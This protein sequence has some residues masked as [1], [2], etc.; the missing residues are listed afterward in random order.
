MQYF[1]GGIQPGSNG[2][3]SRSVLNLID[4]AVFEVVIKKPFDSPDTR[5]RKMEEGREDELY[6]EHFSYAKELPWASVD[7]S[8]RTDEYLSVGTAFAISENQL[9]TAAHVLNLDSKTLWED[10]YIR[11]KSGQVYEL[12]E[13]LKYANNRDFTLFT[14][15]GMGK[16]KHFD[17]ETE[18]E[19]N[20]HV[21]AVGNALGEGV[22]IRDGL[23]TSTTKE[24]E[25]GAWD[26]LR[27]S[28]AAS[29]GNSGGPLLNER[30]RVLGIVL[31][32]S[33]NENLNYALPIG[34]ALDAEANTAV[35]HRFVNYGLAMTYKKYGPVKYTEEIAL[36]LGYKELR[37]NLSRLN[38]EHNR[39]MIDEL[40]RENSDTMFPRGEGSYGLLHKASSYSFPQI[41]AENEEDG[42]WSVYQ[43]NE[44]ESARLGDNGYISF[45]AMADFTIL[46][47]RKP[48]DVSLESLMADSEF[49]IET[50]L[51]AYPLNRYF[52][53][54]SVRIT[55]LGTAD[56]AYTLEDRYQRKWFV[57]SWDIQF[58]DSKLII[59]AMPTPSGFIAL[60][61]LE[62]VA[63]IDQVLSLDMEEYLNYV[64]FSHSG[65]FLEW[66][67][68]L[69]LDIPRSPL[70]DEINFSYTPGTQV[71]FENRWFRVQYGEDVLPVDDKSLLTLKA[72]YIL[73][74]GKPQWAPVGL[75]FTDNF[76]GDNYVMLVRE[77]KPEEYLS[78]G[79][80]E[81]WTNMVLERYPYDGSARIDEETTYANALQRQ[82]AERNVLEIEE[83]G[84]LY[85]VGVGLEG[86]Q[87]EKEIETILER[88]Q[89]GTTVNE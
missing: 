52:G 81:N 13:V 61:M 41:A 6:I 70:V 11:D 40:I 18:Y 75:T 21:Y 71:F 82:F 54:Q 84:L 78:E 7:Y 77:T 4:Q 23:L 22:I 39:R 72:T 17:V 63:S 34:E 12:D 50:F 10:Y 88:F 48:L 38:L 20:H 79:Y 1:P 5:T 43:P 83:E 3:I 55:S 57:Q 49:F 30:G 9:L 33:E 24:F 74:A 89:V 51:E 65:T 25:D 53:N 80:H 26:Y 60:S 32:K 87:K 76:V 46:R 47:F 28:A 29:P 44:I 14:V 66:K 67:E 59:Y 69:A 27:Y 15:K 58:A 8:S 19:L 45:G 42:V 64:F 37:G 2:R 16:M 31:K 56:E 85:F 68:F 36:P 86:T 73:K 62:S 35:Y